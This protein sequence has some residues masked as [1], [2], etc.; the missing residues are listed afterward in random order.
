M[1]ERMPSYAV[2]CLLAAGYDAPDAIS[3]MNIV[4]GPDNSIEVIE[5]FIDQHF[6]GREG[7]YSHRTLASHPFVFPPGH[8]IRIGTFVSEVK[9]LYLPTLISNQK[10]RKRQA[11]NSSSY[12]YTQS[13]SPR[14]AEDNLPCESTLTVTTQI[15]GCISRWIKAQTCDTLK[16][17]VVV[18]SDYKQSGDISVV[19]RCN[20]LKKDIGLHRKSIFKYPIGHGMLNSAENLK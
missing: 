11:S 3:S 15:C 18:V 6:R 14:I 5:K 19:V 12:I 9:K 10:A 13:K 17:F 4:E 16:H 2:N 8:K 7:Y 1:K 20:A